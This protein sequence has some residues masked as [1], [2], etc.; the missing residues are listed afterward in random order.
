MNIERENNKLAIFAVTKKG[1]LLAV[2]LADLIGE[3]VVAYIPKRLETLKLNCKKAKLH[4]FDNWQEAFQNA[5]KEYPGLI[6]IMATGIVVRTMA[7]LLVSKREDPAVVVVDE[8]GA[9]AISLLSG[10]VGGAN[11]LAIDVALRLGG[12]P[13]ITTATDVNK[14]PAIDMLALHIEAEIEPLEHVKLFNRLLVEDEDVLMLSPLPIT[15]AIKDGFVWEN[16]PRDFKEIDKPTVIISPYKHEIN[17]LDS[18]VQLLP[19]NLVVGI[20][21]RKGVSLKDVETAYE[22]VLEKFKIDHRCVKKLATIDFKGEEQAL[23]LLS[24]KLT[25]PLVTV[26]K[27]QIDAL[28][29]TYEPSQWVEQKIGVGGVCEPAA[30][31]AANMGIT[32]VPKQKVGP[33]TISVAVERSWWLDL[34]QGIETF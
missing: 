4:Y 19:K 29:G 18:H 14:K 32:I 21:C 15:D 2:K 31:I 27:V 10:H 34:D 23:K 8:K 1:S 22:S 11:K 30:R 33:V 24:K 6:C 17:M 12:R 28:E 20:G 5:F 16:W 25:I 9:Y 26:T 7:P 3:K 13:V